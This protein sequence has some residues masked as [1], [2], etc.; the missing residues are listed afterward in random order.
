MGRKRGRLSRFMEEGV[1]ELSLAGGGENGGDLPFML[2]AVSAE[3]MAGQAAWCPD[4]W[5]L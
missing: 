3:W 5:C 1:F 2:W 4:S